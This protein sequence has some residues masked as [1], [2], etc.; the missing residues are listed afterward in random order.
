MAKIKQI[1]MAAGTFS[2]ALGI[3]FVMQNGD[4]LAARFGTD[5]AAP[6]RTPFVSDEEAVQPAAFETATADVLPAPA[7]PTPTAEQLAV[8]EAPVVL[9]PEAPTGPAVI[10]PDAAQVTPE[11]EAP[12]QLATVEPEMVPDLSVP[13]TAA[14]PEINCVP[15]MVSVAGA[16]ATVK[17]ALSAP[18]HVETAFTVHHQGMMFT[19][20]TDQDGLASVVV[21]ALAEVAVVIAAFPDG[22]GGV[23]TVTVPDVSNYDRAV[24]QWQGDTAVMLSAY[25]GDAG[26]GAA[27]HIYTDNPGDIARLDAAEGG[28][29]MRLG[30]SDVP[31]A[32]MAE[33]YTFPSGMDARVSEVL[34]VAEAEIT[35]T[36]CGQELNAQSIQVFPTG[37]T[38][39]LDLTLLMPECDAVGDVLILQNMFE[40]LTLAMR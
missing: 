4:A 17:I 23:A 12:M 24:L 14:T 10:L 31:D 34:L 25:E 26:F 22:D 35:D 19:A 36:N 15:E 11:Q 40:D 20:M 2:M 16:G 37:E 33:V 7:A 21:P 29:L 9:N 1:A 6:E 30:A 39:A 8:V 27:G 5:G 32:L 18:C 13:E 38:T 28:F 3:G